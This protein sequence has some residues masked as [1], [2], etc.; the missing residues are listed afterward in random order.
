M[1]K[2]PVLSVGRGAA[3]ADRHGIG[4]HRRVLADD[5]AERL[6]PALHLGERHV[7]RRLG[8]AGDE[9]GVLL[10]EEALGDGS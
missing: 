6:L 3:G 5:L 10:R 4:G 9:A 2:R 8:D 7:L 1:K